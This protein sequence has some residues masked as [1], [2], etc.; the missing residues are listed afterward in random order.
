[1]VNFGH[2][3]VYLPKNMRVAYANPP[4]SVLVEYDKRG[5]GLQEEG[6]TA[7]KPA[8]VDQMDANADMTTGTDT[9]ADRN[10]PPDRK[11]VT[12][13]DKVQVLTGK[14]VHRHTGL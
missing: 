2:T 14:G 5:G 3:P 11:Q 13:M 1:M 7:D 10:D 4:P 12:F 6:V 9:I 8:N